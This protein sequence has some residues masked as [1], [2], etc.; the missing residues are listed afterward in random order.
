MPDRQRS[1]SP[2]PYP[3]RIAGPLQT[4]TFPNRAPLQMSGFVR[5]PRYGL[6]LGHPCKSLVFSSRAHRCKP[7]VFLCRGLQVRYK[8]LQGLQGVCSLQ[9][10]R[11]VQ[12]G[13]RRL[14]GSPAR[15]TCRSE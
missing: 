5:L 3:P 11:A 9:N 4:L 10:V 6:L 13:R 14:S 2:A 8:V 7:K 12:L 15:A 1:V